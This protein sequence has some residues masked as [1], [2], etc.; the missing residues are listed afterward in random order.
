MSTVKQLAKEQRIQQLGTEWAF[1]EGTTKW[2]GPK[3]EW[4]GKDSPADKSAHA[5][6]CV[7]DAISAVARRY[8]SFP[9]SEAHA[10]QTARKS[11]LR[12]FRDGEPIYSC[13]DMAI[14]RDVMESAIELDRERSA[15]FE[16]A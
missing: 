16:A 13:D 8:K 4:N 10:G 14:A 5:Y 9:C 7:E 12:L 1:Y 3:K 2:I 11:L 15:I 6:W